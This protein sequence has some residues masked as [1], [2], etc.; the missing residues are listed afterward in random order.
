MNPNG[1]T[2]AE[3]NFQ[4]IK[5]MTDLHNNTS[6]KIEKREY[7]HNKG[8]TTSRVVGKEQSLSIEVDLTLSLPSHRYLFDLFVS[9]ADDLNNQYMRLELHA[10]NREDNKYAII[11]GK[12]MIKFNDG[13]PSGKPTEITKMKLDI[14]PQDYTWV[15][16][17]REY[18]G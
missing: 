10:I 13:I 7:Y 18:T 4:E 14:A 1:S 3:K 12:C 11:M 15:Y 2:E 8:E 16:E 5:F 17:D 6:H 9:S